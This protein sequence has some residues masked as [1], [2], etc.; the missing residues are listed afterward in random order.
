[1]NWKKIL[2]GLI[3]FSV[4]FSMCQKCVDTITG[5]KESSVASTPIPVPVAE[6]FKLMEATNIS[7]LEKMYGVASEKKNHD[8]KYP[9]ENS[10]CEKLI[11]QNKNEAI[12]NNKGEVYWLTI[13]NHEGNNFDDNTIQFS[14]GLKYEKPDFENTF[15]KRWNNYNGWAI[16]INGGDGKV[17]FILCKKLSQTTI[18]DNDCQSR[19]TNNFSAWDGSYAPLVTA[20]KQGMNDADSFEHVKTTFEK[21]KKSGYLVLMAYRGSNAFGAK[22]LTSIKIKVDCDGSM[23]EIK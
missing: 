5:K 10:K 14:L 3:A 7:Y 20:V 19:F 8:N 23:K 9:C 15:V 2:F 6:T 21:A 22:I 1:M 13:Y 4:L 11:F 18:D 16:D 17:S 12:L